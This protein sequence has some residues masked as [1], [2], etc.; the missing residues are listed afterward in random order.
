MN[1]LDKIVQTKKEELTYQKSLVTID[2]LIK[3]SYFDQRCHSTVANL[4][5]A[6]P[7]G[8]ISEFKRQ[9]PSKGV[10][11]DQVDVAQVAKGYCEA[12]ASAISILT[13][14]DYFGGSVED[15][16]RARKHMTC[17]VL[18]KDFIIDE[19][20]I[21]KTKAIG[22]DLMLLIAAILTKEE[23]I[24]FTDLAHQLGLEVLLEIHNEEEYREGYYDA[25]D[26]LGVNNRDLK[27]FKTTI[28]NSIDLAKILPKD[29]LKIS[30]S[31]ISST[32]EMD[33]L[34]AEGYKGFLIGEQFMKHA[35]PANELKKFMNT[36]LTKG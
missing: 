9:S 12:G 14:R 13:D 5:S 24:R 36:Q 30:E 35:D 6:A 15:L 18:R 19:Y 16:Q 28:Q 3:S 20:Q 26:I 22:A 11:N 21:Y 17:P 25:V 7:Y 8:I 32:K 27:R 4:E 29:Q 33:I 10:I 23:I 34:A 2:D 1:V 31:G